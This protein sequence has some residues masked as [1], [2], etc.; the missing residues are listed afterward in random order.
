MNHYSSLLVSKVKL[1]LTLCR[2]ILHTSGRNKGLKKSYPFNIK[3]RGGYS[4]AGISTHLQTDPK[5]HPTSSTVYTGSFLGIKRPETGI[6]HPPLPAPR[7]WVSIAIPLFEIY[8]FKACYKIDL[9][10]Y[11]VQKQN[12]VPKFMK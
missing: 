9:Y 12:F 6:D 11:H 10:L 8:D 7:L 2:R 5:A 4:S 1:N 3:K